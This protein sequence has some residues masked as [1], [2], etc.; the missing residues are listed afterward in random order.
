MNLGLGVAALVLVALV[1]LLLP[2][3]RDNSAPRARGW[4]AVALLAGVP[5][6]TVALYT[7]LG[8]PAIVEA[9]ALTQAQAEY[10]VDAMVAALENKLKKE[11]GDADGWYALGRAYIALQR[12]NDAEAAL[13]RAVELAPKQAR[14][15][16]QYA[17][18]IALQSGSLEGRPVQLVMAALEL[19][20]DDEKG[21]ELAGLAAYQRQD[22]AQALYFWRRLMKQLPK[23][24]EL[25]EGIA[26]AVK[27]AE[28]KVTAASGLG[29][30]ARLDAAQKKNT[31]H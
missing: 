16:A 4:S 2:L 26:L 31:P 13:A 1:F 3:W 8:A 29:E 23:E 6:L 12:L 28:T 7:Y 18:A 30:R 17:E 27:I 11:P 5:C 24:S 14:I 15:L 22:W 9:R 20:F 10:D 19:D 25:Y 21:L